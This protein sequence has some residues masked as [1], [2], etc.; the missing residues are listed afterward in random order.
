M[1]R[2]VC[3]RITFYF[4]IS[5]AMFVVLTGDTLGNLYV[6]VDNRRTLLKSSN[7]YWLLVEQTD[8]GIIFTIS[9]KYKGAVAEGCKNIPGNQLFSIILAERSMQG[10]HQ[11]V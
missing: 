10:R 9:T 4:V 6:H 8:D 7:E 11:V 1:V 5:F 3:I 2:E